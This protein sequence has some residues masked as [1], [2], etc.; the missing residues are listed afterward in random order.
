MALQSDLVWNEEL[1]DF[2]AVHE[3]SVH[4]DVLTT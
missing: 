4:E 3:E 2:P 1:L